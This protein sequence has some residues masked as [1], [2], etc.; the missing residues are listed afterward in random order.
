MVA[1]AREMRLNQNE[2]TTVTEISAGE[3]AHVSAWAVTKDGEQA[4]SHVRLSWRI[5][6]GPLPEVQVQTAIGGTYSVLVT[7][8]GPT[9]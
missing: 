1:V 6:Q 2:W 7:S 5:T 4:L 9:N 8:V 3:L